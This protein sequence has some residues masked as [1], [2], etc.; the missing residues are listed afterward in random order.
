MRPSLII[1]DDFLANPHDVRDLA[2]RLNFPEP[3]K[4]MPYPGR[5][6]RQKLVIEGLDDVVSRYLG[7]PV[8]PAPN[9]GHGHCRIT[10][11]KDK[12]RGDVHIDTGDWSGILYLTLPEDCRGGTDFFRHKETGTDRAPITQPELEAMG[13]ATFAEMVQKI[14]K[15]DGT[16]RDKWE[17]IMQI[18]MRFNRLVL[19]RP[20][21]WHSPGS[22]FG[23][24]RNNGRLI[25][26]MFYAG[27][28]W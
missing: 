5:N 15:P 7:E 4:Q 9:T 22:G 27:P 6:S 14:I 3:E 28:G 13:F 10:L 19:L 16:D 25:Y 23:D 12:G 11:A 26:L 2:L 24:D 18:P 17:H 8:K 1:F 20:W 21:L